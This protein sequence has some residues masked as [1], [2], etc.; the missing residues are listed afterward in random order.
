MPRKIIIAEDDENVREALQDFLSEI[1]EDC[2]ISTASNGRELVDK[3]RNE[4]Y[5]LIITDY[6]MPLLDGLEAVRQIRKFDKIIPI[7]VQSGM[8]VEKLV[9]EAGASEYI[10]KLNFGKLSERIKF[11][12]D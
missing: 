12:L 5:D 6:Q 10:D 1:I 11:Y 8:P 4:D 2:K 7:I 3:V 9:L